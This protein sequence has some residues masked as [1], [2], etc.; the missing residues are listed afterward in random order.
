MINML[1]K[2]FFGESFKNKVHLYLSGSQAVSYG[3]GKLAVED[4]M[5]METLVQLIYEW[6][7]NWLMDY[8]EDV[9][10]DWD[11]DEDDAFA[12]L[13]CDCGTL[14]VDCEVLDNNYRYIWDDFE[15]VPNDEE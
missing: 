15:I 4:D 2:D 7:S 3:W 14:Y 6:R 9:L 12:D 11:G 13:E 10:D 8:V 5:T 1:V